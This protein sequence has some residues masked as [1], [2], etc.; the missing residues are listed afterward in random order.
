MSH[1]L[2][3]FLGRVQ[4]EQGSYRTTV[5]DFG[6]GPQEAPTAFFGWPLQRRLQPDRLVILGTA[7]SMWE[8]LFE[9]DLEFGDAEQDARDA[10]Y[11]AV[12]RKLVT[13]S[14]LEPLAP[15][16]SERLGCEVVLDLIPYCRDEAEQVRLLEIMASHVARG[17]RVDLDVTH[18]FRH[19]PMVALLSALQLQILRQAEV[20]GIWYGSY[21]P[22]TKEA[23]VYRLGGLLQIA[24]WLQALHTYDKDGDYSVFCDLLATTA[25]VSSESLRQA[26]FHEKTN[27][28]GQA[29]APLRKFRQGFEA[30]HPD[31]LLQLFADE[32]RS[33]TAW[34]DQQSLTERQYELALH[35]LE[36]GDYLRAAILGFESL[37][38]RLVQASPQSLQPL[39]HTH[40]DGIKREWDE[41]IR[42]QGQQRTETQKAYLD[43]REIRNALAHGSLSSFGHIQ[44]ALASEANLSEALRKAIALAHQGVTP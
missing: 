20:N 23:P 21:D 7:G 33:R 19:L 34:V 1:V 37:I 12:D 15:L 24:G 31:P 22:D 42:R 38:T 14:H 2:L 17:D 41:A 36:H 5:Y 27:N 26:A 16:L 28:I 32:L 11:E 29:R 13:A 18:G 4:K 10:L 30:V 40:R 35:F 43:L 25:S 6:D 8:H 3:T 44:S 39:N 9:G